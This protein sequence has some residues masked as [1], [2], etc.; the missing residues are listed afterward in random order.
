M[1]R[2]VMGWAVLLWAGCT[3]DAPSAIT[4]SAGETR[5]GYLCVDGYWVDDSSNLDASRPDVS[6][7]TGDQDTGKTDVG[8][9]DTGHDASD[10]GSD[11]DMGCVAP[12]AEEFCAALGKNCGTVN[13]MD[14]CGTD[15]TE[16]CGNCVAPDTCQGD[17]TCTCE[18]ETD[19]A[20]CARLGKDC[21]SVTDADNCGVQRTADC[22][23]CSGN[24][25]CG[26]GAPNVCG[27]PCLIEGVC[28]ADG[29]KNPNN[30][31]E[32]C[33][34]GSNDM[35]W[36]VTANATCNDGDNCTENDRCSAA[37]VCAGSAKDCSNL[38]NTCRTGVCDASN[39]NCVTTPQPDNTPC[40]ADNF[41]CTDDVCQGGNCEHPLKPDVCFINNQCVS[42]NATNPSN[43]C[44]K[45]NPGVNITTW[46]A[47]NGASC[48]DGVSCTTNDVC[49]G[50]TCGGTLVGC[51]INNACVA[52][53][54]PRDNTSCF[55]CEPTVNPSTFTML[56]QGSACPVQDN[57]A[58]TTQACGSTG[59]CEATIDAGFCVINNQCIVSGTQNPA[60]ECQTCNPAVSTTAWSNKANN[61]SC[62]GGTGGCA[63]QQGTCQKTNGTV[64]Q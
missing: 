45:C 36:T 48:N 15:R 33:V 13:A 24:E 38:T 64:C 16:S 40:A 52:E 39:G 63:C 41:A 50:S 8:P 60:N 9:A 61:T 2:L 51:F 18:A 35:G 27:C 59:N 17:N 44:Q 20:F 21:G 31:C 5:A 32:A 14:R 23:M 56:P 29:T 30:P 26:E 6:N 49:S 7:D 47:N 55:V 57:L 28:V 11:A 37:G 54:T 43:A 22:G 3:Y 53:D 25:T 34:P 12:T 19:D 42:N 58:C 10:T 4:C 1:R 62:N 46:S